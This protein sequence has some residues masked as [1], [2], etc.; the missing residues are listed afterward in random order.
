MGS[1]VWIKESMEKVYASGEW[2]Y[3]DNT[4]ILMSSEHDYYTTLEYVPTDTIFIKAH[5]FDVGCDDGVSH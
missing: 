1:P 5:R 3:S 4:K 2:Y